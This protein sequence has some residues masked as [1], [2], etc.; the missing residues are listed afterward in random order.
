M[1]NTN[2]SKMKKQEL[3]ELAVSNLTE[4]GSN[5][6]KSLKDR[7]AYTQKQFKANEKDVPKD[8]LLQLIRDISTSISTLKGIDPKM[9]IEASAKP[10]LKA[11]AKKTE[12]HPTTPP[13]TPKEE[14][15]KEDTKTE[16]KVTP[17]VET[18]E[19]LT[20]DDIQMARIFPSEI[21]HELGKLVAVPEKYSTMEEVSKAIEEGVNVYFAAYWTKRHLKENKYALVHD[22]PVSKKGFD[23]DL[24]MLQ[25]IYVCEGVKRLFAISTA[26][27]AMFRF[28]EEDLERIECESPTGEKFTMRYSAGLEY[29]IYELV[30]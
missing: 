28:D 17:K 8:I 18:T 27:E 10:K 26:T 11:P 5:A 6:D 13:A 23:F 25:T 15:P 4:L 21:D 30:E 2:V 24:D 7:V 29:E 12:E 1:N 16:E 20:K 3:M 14:K 19:G 9:P 22:V